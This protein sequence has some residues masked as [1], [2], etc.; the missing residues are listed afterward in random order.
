M[1]ENNDDALEALFIVEWYASSLNDS[2]RSDDDRE[3]A[4][5]EVM[6]LLNASALTQDARASVVRVVLTV[7]RCSCDARRAVEEKKTRDESRRRTLAVRCVA[8]V[9]CL[10][11]AF[12]AT[13]RSVP[14]TATFALGCFVAITC[15]EIASWIRDV[16]VSRVK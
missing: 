6:E 13:A 7:L 1:K 5:A 10:I 11:V 14:Q 15:P 3:K 16:F 9:L 8:A 2:L 12:V 4:F